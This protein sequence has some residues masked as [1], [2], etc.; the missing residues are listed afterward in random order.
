MQLTK[1]QFLDLYPCADA[2]AFAKSIK[3]DAV[4]GWKADKIR[5]IVKCPFTS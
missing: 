2:L 1:Q 5:E 3:F 4:R